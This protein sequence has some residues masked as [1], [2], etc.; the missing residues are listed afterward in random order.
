[1]NNRTKQIKTKL[2]GQTNNVWNSMIVGVGSHGSCCVGI[3]V[4]LFVGLFVGPLIASN[5]LLLICFHPPIDAMNIVLIRLL[6]AG[7]L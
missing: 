1:M 4:G 7:I 5:D 2:P 6:A 3:I